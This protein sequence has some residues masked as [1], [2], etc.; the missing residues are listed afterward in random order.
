MNQAMDHAERAD[1]SAERTMVNRRCSIYLAAE[2]MDLVWSLSDVRKFDAAWRDDVP[3]AE[4]ANMLGRD[5]DEVAILAIDRARRG[6][7]QPRK[8][9][10]F[11]K[12]ATPC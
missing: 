10:L 4:I 7:I 8:G 12:V 1:R 9:G 5:T 2:D 3:L 11:G 6:R